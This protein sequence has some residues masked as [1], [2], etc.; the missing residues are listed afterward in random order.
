MDGARSHKRD[1]NPKPTWAD[2]KNGLHLK[3]DVVAFLEQLSVEFNPAAAAADLAL[4]VKEHHS[5][6]KYAVREI[7]AKFGH[8]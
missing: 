4:K 6:P 7:A 3:S 1:T 8:E 5:K 2:S